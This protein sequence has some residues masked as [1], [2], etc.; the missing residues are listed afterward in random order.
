MTSGKVTHQPSQFLRGPTTEHCLLAAVLQQLGNKSFT[1]EKGS[2]SCI[3]VSTKTPESVVSRQRM[4]M[5]EDMEEI[6]NKLGYKIP[7]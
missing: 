2:V 6:T 4:R 5:N 7:F 1:N 3:I